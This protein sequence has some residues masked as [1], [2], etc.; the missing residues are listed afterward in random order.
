MQILFESCSVLKPYKQQVSQILNKFRTYKS[1]VPVMGAI[2]LDPEMEHCL[3]LRGVK[4]SASY[5]FP[6]GKVNQ[7]EEMTKENQ[8]VNQEKETKE[9]RKVN[10]QNNLVMP[11][12]LKKFL[13]SIMIILLLQM[14]KE[15]LMKEIVVIVVRGLPVT[16]LVKFL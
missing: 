4:S 10:Q 14:F 12:P 2:I 11:K 9:N 8:K 1:Q 3:L 13:I 15:L 5:G 7:E 6:K 16:I